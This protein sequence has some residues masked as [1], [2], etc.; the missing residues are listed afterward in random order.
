MGIHDFIKSAFNSTIDILSG[1]DVTISGVTV[2]GVIDDMGYEMSLGEGAENNQRNLRITFAGASFT[3]TP[4]SGNSVSTR[5][6]IWKI[7]RVDESP[8]CL[9]IDLIEHERRK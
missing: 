2:K 9:T 3:T 8:A 6:K 5:G 7:T 4:R 1:E